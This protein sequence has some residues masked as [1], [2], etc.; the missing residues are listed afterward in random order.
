MLDEFMALWYN[1]IVFESILFKPSCLNL[2]RPN[3]SCSEPSCSNPSIFKS[4]L[5]DFGSGYTERF[6][7]CFC[8]RQRSGWTRNRYFRFDHSCQRCKFGVCRCRL[9]RS[10]LS[11]KK[12]FSRVDGQGQK[13]HRKKTQPPSDLCRKETEPWSIILTSPPKSWKPS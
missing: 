13:A 3:L 8:T 10:F 11:P 6:K 5:E 7:L 4:Q 12:P 2:S 9:I 1:A